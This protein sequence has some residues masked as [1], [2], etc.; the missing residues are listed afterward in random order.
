MLCI[1]S[2]HQIL[3][4]ENSPL[5]NPL[6]SQSKQKRN[7]WSVETADHTQC[8][9]HSEGRIWRRPPLGPS[10]WCIGLAQRLPG[11]SSGPGLPKIIK[12]QYKRLNYSCV[13]HIRESDSWSHP[14][15]N[16][17]STG[18]HRRVTMT[19]SATVFA[20]VG[21]TAGTSSARVGARAWTTIVSAGA[22]VRTGSA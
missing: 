10:L 12:R 14:V 20:A 4:P 18:R 8:W 17:T 11:S 13:K 3:Q 21:A 22:P 1:N 16:M 15:T 2:I 5:L 6:C 19:A 7:P 9:H